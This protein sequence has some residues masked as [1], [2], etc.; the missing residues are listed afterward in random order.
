MTDCAPIKL[1]SQRLLNSPIFDAA[2]LGDSCCA[3][4]G[5]DDGDEFRVR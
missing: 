2:S 1:S 5:D 4:D 3:D